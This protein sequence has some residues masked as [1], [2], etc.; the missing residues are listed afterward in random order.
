[1]PLRCKGLS[2]YQRNFLWEKSRPSENGNSLKPKKCQWAGLRSDQLG[3]TREPGF[4]SKRRV[5]Y[6][7]P[8][9]AKSLEWK[10]DDVSDSD[11][12]ERR[13]PNI[14]PLLQLPGTS[15]EEDGGHERL[16]TTV[17]PKAPRRN[18][19][20][21]ADSRIESPRD[22]TG[23]KQAPPQPASAKRKD[24]FEP[25][26]REA[27]NVDEGLARV[28]KKRSGLNVAPL[29]HALRNSEYQRQ[30][31]WKTCKE[32]SPMLAAEQI[33]HR[34]RSVLPHKIDAPVPETEYSRNFRG[35]S[36]V[37]ETRL[38]CDLEEKRNPEN[39]SLGKKSQT[40]DGSV[41][42]GRAETEA[43][44]PSQPK[45]KV[46]PWKLKRLGKENT[47]Y[48]S[49]FLSPALYFYQDGAWIR[50]KGKATDQGFQG[51]LNSMWYNEV[52][53][54]REKAEAYRKRGQGTH[55]SRDHLNQILSENNRLWDVSSSS[56]SEE[57]ISNNIRA[58]D[59]AGLSPH[60]GSA[61]EEERTASEEA[62]ARNS[63]G[64][65]GP[66]EAA[67]VPSRRRLAWSA[68]DGERVP[69]HS[70]VDG[71]EEENKKEGVEE[72]ERLGEKDR[73]A[74]TDD[75]KEDGENA[76]LHSAGLDRSD[77]PSVSSGKGGRLPTPKLKDLG[78][79]Q[80]THHD[81]TTPAVGGAVLVSPTK[82]KPSYPEP[83]KD[84]SI[85]DLSGSSSKSKLS[86]KENVLVAASPTAG[87]KTVDPLPLR[88]EVEAPGS[89]EAPLPTS[90]PPAPR[91]PSPRHPSR[92]IRGSLRDPEFQ[93][94]GNLMSP[95]IPSHFQ[96]P[97]RDEPCN[98]EDDRLS[99][100][101]A[102]SAASSLL[103]LQTLARAQR[104]KEG[105]WNKK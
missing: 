93:H 2:E 72:V 18:R 87:V 47:E 76:S 30:F 16:E 92:R 21:S 48:G 84:A 104:R 7:N 15:E 75:T 68:G 99:Q 71:E 25:S 60:Q 42:Q 100:I 59:L 9:I 89:A 77:S 43:K 85:F 73:N 70:P 58:L 36:P 45:H 54:L 50:A 61:A 98:D 94:N 49:K 35:S 51:T 27:R 96:L 64:K 3:I 74:Q 67:T 103:A 80:R 1:M 39:K 28:L 97:R 6:Y 31:V 24:T 88:E 69:H 13:E 105:F 52:R 33:F 11:G 8:E 66:S 10:E 90:R 37:K 19:S 20:L 14:P 17:V 101:S 57:T 65:L 32:P 53:E 38:K 5:P 46:T 62:K 55:F 56:S 95:R 4:I 34:N 44:E 40:E 26:K 81:L 41:E 29:S 82:R 63:T 12:P 22:P 78:G 86:R 83:R 91:A 79:P 102:H 23:N